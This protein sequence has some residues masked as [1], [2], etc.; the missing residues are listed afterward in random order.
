MRWLEDLAEFNFKLR[1][2]KGKFNLV[3]DA[4]SRMYDSTSRKLYDGV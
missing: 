1:Y 3:A 2:V 4:L